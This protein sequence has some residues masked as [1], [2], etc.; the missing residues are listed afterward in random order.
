MVITGRSKIGHSSIPEVN[1][2]FNLRGL[3]ESPSKKNFDNNT[4]EV[5]TFPP[6]MA[7]TVW[8]LLIVLERRSDKMF[9]VGKIS[10]KCAKK[11][12]INFF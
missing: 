9:K 7:L 4:L 1:V 5:L 3:K 12:I 8:P 6:V 11:E 10:L 2:E